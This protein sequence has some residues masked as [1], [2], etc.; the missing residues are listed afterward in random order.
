M[1]LCIVHDVSEH[2]LFKGMSGCIESHETLLEM[3]K[4]PVV[5]VQYQQKVIVKVSSNELK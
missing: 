2:H 5:I 4:Q 1:N 3:E